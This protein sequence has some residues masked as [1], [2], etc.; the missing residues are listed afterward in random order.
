MP[1]R[2][3]HQLVSLVLLM[4]VSAMASA[5]DEAFIVT[6]DDHYIEMHTGPGRGFPIFYVAE[7]GEKITILKERAGWYKVRNYRAIE[8]WVSSNQI[9]LTLDANGNPIILDEPGLQT[10]SN[11][12]WEGGLMLGDFGGSDILTIYGGYQFTRNLSLEL[13]LSESYGEFSTGDA[14]SLSIVHQFAPQWRYSPFFTIGAGIRRT[15]PK[16]TLVS[17]EDR[18]DGTANVGLGVRIYLNRQF[19]LRLQYKQY[20]VL[21]SRDDDEEVEEWKIGLSAF[22]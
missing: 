21:T 19:F 22:F 3:L 2:V 13:A 11:R 14:A 17:V 15:E 1:R 6:V 7:R 12:R 10:F 18:D 8:G 4:L 9:I 20:L 5:D 16:S